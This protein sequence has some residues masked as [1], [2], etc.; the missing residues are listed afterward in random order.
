MGLALSWHIQPTYRQ[1]RTQDTHGPGTRLI[2]IA[3]W[4]VLSWYIQPTDREGKTQEAHGPGTQLTYT[5][6]WQARKDTRGP[7]AWHSADIPWILRY[8]KSRLLLLLLL[9]LYYYY[10]YSQL[11][12]KEKHKMI[13]GLA[14][15]WY[16]Q[17]TVRQRKDTRG[18]WAWHSADIYIANRQARAETRGSWV[19]HSA[20]I[21]IANCQA[22]KTTRGPWAWHSAGI[23]T[24]N[25]QARKGTRGRGPGTKLTYIANRQARTDTRGLWAWHSADIF[26]QLTGKGRHKRPMGLALSWQVQPTDRKRKERKK[27]KRG[28]W[29][30]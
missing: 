27:D 25:W 21:Y 19:W 30:Q 6:N 12:S 7:W 9:L 26:S 28:P 22:R 29:V 18:P 17:P 15:I 4:R 1:G 11:T 24:D 5:V 14:L 3:N 2:Y 23:Y 20:D 8:I 10:I 13:V 16:I